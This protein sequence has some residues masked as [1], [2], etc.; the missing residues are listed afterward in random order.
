[1]K[2]KVLGEIQ[3]QHAKLPTKAKAIKAT[4]AES[5]FE[6]KKMEETPKPK[7]QEQSIGNILKPQD[8]RCRRLQKYSSP[9][10]TKLLTSS[11]VILLHPSPA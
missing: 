2:R 3:V 4:K 10:N 1:M 11:Q 8:K 6:K 9:T 7:K 5:N